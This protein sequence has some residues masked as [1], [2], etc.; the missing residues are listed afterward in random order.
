MD[1]DRT[2]QTPGCLACAHA[3]RAAAVDQVEPA[4]IRSVTVDPEGRDYA[5]VVRARGVAKPTEIYAPRTV[6][7]VTA[8]IEALL[9]GQ[10]VPRHYRGL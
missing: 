3:S 8:V 10:P 4:D 9:T 7:G 2:T 5:V 1:E 6:R